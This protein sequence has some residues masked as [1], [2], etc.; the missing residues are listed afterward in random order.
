MVFSSYLLGFVILAEAG[1]LHLPQVQLSQLRADLREQ[2][3]T[4]TL[5]CTKASEVWE[6]YGFPRGITGC[7]EAGFVLV[8][9]PRNTSVVC[10]TTFVCLS[11]LQAADSHRVFVFFF[12]SGDTA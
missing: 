5:L 1:R 12:A 2:G 6:R 9:E 8:I 11:A 3:V 10:G 7:V 4:C